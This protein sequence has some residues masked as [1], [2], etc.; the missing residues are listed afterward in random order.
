MTDLT[1]FFKTDLVDDHVAN[2]VN[3]LIAAALR[4]EYANTESITATKELTDNDCQFQ[5]ITA[6]G[7]E[8]TVELAPEA[9][10]NHITIIYNPGSTYSVLVKDDSGVTLFKTLAPGE[11]CVF[12]PFLGSTWKVWQPVSLFGLYQITDSWSYASATTI[13]VPSGATNLYQKGDKLRLVQSNT[14]KYFYVIGIASTTLTVFGGSDYSVA[15]SAISDI[16]LSRQQNPFGFPL[17]HNYTPSTLTTITTG[18]GTLSC[19]MRMDG[20]MTKTWVDF[21]FGS[22]SSMGSGA[23][24]CSTPFTLNVGAD[25]LQGRG[26][27]LD[28]GTT[29]FAL[30]VEISNTLI[31]IYRMIVSGSE[32]TRSAFSST[33]PMTWT[34][35]DKLTVQCEGLIA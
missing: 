18:N 26:L 8:R 7:A 15:N 13:T 31:S 21:T 12:L 5:I 10:S 20:P 32:I 9:S 27:I 14:T 33:T 24:T 25:A 3:V 29:R 4:A 6:S 23:V 1:S 17:Y 30:F 16:Y 34:T 28:S 11:W 35:G 19:R 2:D 22:T